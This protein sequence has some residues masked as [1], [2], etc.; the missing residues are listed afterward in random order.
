MLFVFDGVDEVPVSNV[1]NSRKWYPR[2]LLLSGLSAALREWS[3]SGNRVL[4]TSRPYGVSESDR[5]RLQW[6]NAA[7]QE[8]VNTFETTSSRI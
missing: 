8:C 7:I 6:T 1:R 4:L 5:Q 2:A 3:K